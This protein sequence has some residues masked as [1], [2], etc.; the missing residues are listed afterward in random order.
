MTSI[1]DFCNSKN[2]LWF[3]IMLTINATEKLQNGETKFK[4]DLVF[5]RY[6]P[7]STDFDNLPVETILARQSLLKTHRNEFNAIAIDCRKYY[8]VDY[9]TPDFPEDLNDFIH[10]NPFYRSATKSYGKHVFIEAR[11]PH[12][13]DRHV[14]YETEQGDV[15]ILTK[16][17][18]AS[19]D[20]V[21]EN[22]HRPIIYYTPDEMEDY[23]CKPQPKQKTKTTTTTTN[24]EYGKNDKYIELMHHVMDAI[25]PKAGVYDDWLKLTGWA[26]NHITREQ[27]LEKIDEDYLQQT[28]K[29]W[30]DFASCPREISIFAIENL[31]KKHCRD[32][33]KEWCKTYKKMISLDILRKGEND[34]CEFVSKK[35]RE[36]LIFCNNKWYG[37]NINTRI[38]DIGINPTAL[39]IK[40]IQDE[41]SIL[42]SYIDDSLPNKSGEDRIKAEKEIEELNKFYR[43]VTGGSYSSQCKKCLE[44][45]LADNQFYKKL[46]N[47]P[48]RIPFKN[49][50]YNLKTKTL[51]HDIQADDY[52]SSTLQRNYTPSTEQERNL[53]KEELLKI[54]NCNHIHLDYYL[55]I[56][57]YSMCGVAY[58]EQTFW[59]MYGPTASNGKSTV[60][61]ALH[62]I[63][64]ELIYSVSS[65]FFEENQKTRHKTI[66][67]F[68][69]LTRIIYANELTKKKQD[70]EFIKQMA[71]GTTISYGQ[72][73]GNKVDLPVNFKCFVISNNLL[74]FDNDNGIE[75]RLKTCEFTSSFH[76]DNT[77]DDFSSRIFKPNKDFPTD[78][79]GK[80]SNALLD[81]IFEYSY[82][83][84]NENKLK[85]YPVEWDRENKLVVSSNNIYKDIFDNEFEYGE[86]YMIHKD[87][88][89]RILQQHGIIY[90]QKEF[91]GELKRFPC[92]I[93]VYNI[94]YD[95]QKQD[96]S[97]GKKLK[98]FWIGMREKQDKSCP[99]EC[100]EEF[101]E[102]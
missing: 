23:G 68:S 87:D 36:T 15:E 63:C 93:N 31:A 13:N 59:S 42:R 54:C 62:D 9:D 22:T 4:K 57:G 61:D 75:R 12:I 82:H 73:Y 40:S 2:I 77:V 25:K 24:V 51:E 17:S 53:L 43:Q 56:L 102:I 11:V 38:W 90:K 37:F 45:F 3:P 81:L 86:D 98:G 101:I 39:I 79:R 21:V 95:C 67:T 19:L 70:K 92:Y 78:L 34:V 30:D 5:S 33:Y 35:L 58:K 55:S 66:D 71:D 96:Y 27:F 41:I 52:I 84:A 60:F 20:A 48:Y 8:Q 65:D 16:W 85:S 44:Y 14:I 91:L 47:L 7:K 64:P 76:V 97:T 10:A 94:R 99:E 28:E 74:N 29:M 26:V 88:M 89:T 72:M 18:W 69:S 1:I 80:W 83:Y 50:I 6:M 46:N 100:P 49:G 32:K